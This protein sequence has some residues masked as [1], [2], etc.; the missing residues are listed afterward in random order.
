[1]VF[2]YS[3]YIIVLLGVLNSCKSKK[4]IDKS[5]NSY[6]FTEVIKGGHSPFETEKNIVI[7]DF[8][9]YEKL[10]ADI[11][12][13]REPKPTLPP[14]DFK[15]DML[16]ALFMGMKN[17]GGYGISIDSIVSN[18]KEL[19]VFVKK[20]N[21]KGR[22]TSVMTQPFYLAKIKKTDKKIIFK[23]LAIK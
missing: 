2:K 19:H 14:L 21:P 23:E 9:T 7:T 20:T 4:N 17:S 16:L 6:S 10:F 12:Q 8:V 18:D 11:Y 5:D 3:F 1:M 13:Y 15:N 22:A